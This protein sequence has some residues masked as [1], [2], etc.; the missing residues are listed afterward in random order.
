MDFIL[1]RGFFGTNAPFFIDFSL[2]IFF[3]VPFFMVGA[4]FLARKEF[5]K[6]HIIIQLVLFSVTTLI[7]LIDI[8]GVFH[9]NLKLKNPIIFYGYLIYLL[10]FYT[11]WYRTLYFAIEDSK[12]MALPGLYSKTHKSGG[13]IVVV[14]AILNPILGMIAYYLNFI[15]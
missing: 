15:Y 13:R 4:I 2:I 12:R 5:I 6:A 8:Y 3:L 7:L 1:Q 9:I 14:L 11:I 10:I